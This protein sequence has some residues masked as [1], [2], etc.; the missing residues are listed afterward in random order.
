M[1]HVRSYHV[2]NSDYSKRRIQPWDV[3]L[4]YD[5]NPW[6]ADIIKRILRTKKGDSRV[7]DYEK[8]IH[9]CEERIRQLNLNDTTVISGNGKGFR[10]GHQ[11]LLRA[12]TSCNTQ[13]SIDYFKGL[14]AEN[15]IRAASLRK[16]RIRACALNSYGT[17]AERAVHRGCAPCRDY[18]HMFR[19]F[20]EIT[21]KSLTYLVKRIH[22]K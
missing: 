9:I 11:V 16:S 22:S 14:Q 4:E 18:K 10:D 12:N 6:D 15:Y 3:W 17:I 20:K 13:Y 8:V 2:G 1:K 7:M 19:V 21:R 5:L